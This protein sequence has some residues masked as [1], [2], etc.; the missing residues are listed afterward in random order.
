MYT[1]LHIQCTQAHMYVYTHIQVNTYIYTCTYTYTFAHIVR[2]ELF[3]SWADQV[4]CKGN[5]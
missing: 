4:T 1:Y 3:A 2:V 5:F